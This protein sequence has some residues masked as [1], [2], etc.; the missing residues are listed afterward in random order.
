MSCERCV[1]GW[2]VWREDGP[3]EPVYRKVPCSSCEEGLTAAGIP[4]RYQGAD[5]TDFKPEVTS[6]LRTWGARAPGWIIQGPVGTGKTHLAAALV[7]SL[8]GH[9]VHAQMIF[10]PDLL[11]TIRRTFNP[12]TR[13]AAAMKLRW[14]N[15]AEVLVLDDLGAER[16]T[17]FARDELTK[18]VNDRYV[19]QRAVVITTN[20]SLPELEERLGERRTASRLAEMT[21]P[22]VLGG[23]DRRLKVVAS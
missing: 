6:K 14:V 11:E 22:L 4:S 8:L 12:E 2:M 15:A 16:V 1:G 17:D 10:G 7:S 21:Q 9:D 5:F 18:L 13:D 19:T 3:D 20:L 23:R